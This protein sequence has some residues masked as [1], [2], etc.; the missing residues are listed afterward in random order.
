MASTLVVGPGIQV[1][2][3][4]LGEGERQIARRARDAWA[5]ERAGR[6]LGVRIALNTWAPNRRP[7]ASEDAR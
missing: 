4:P 7:S 3:G 5:G 6:R 2:C 1:C